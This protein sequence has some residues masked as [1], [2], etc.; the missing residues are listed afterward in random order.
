MARFQVTSQSLS[1]GAAQLDV[2][3]EQSAVLLSDAAEGTPAAA[4]WSALSGQSTQAAA[5]GARAVEGLRTAL[6][7]AAAAYELSEQTATT[8]FTG[9]GL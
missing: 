4:A 9:N 7:T 8:L 2:Q 6:L 3:L 5:T 1:E